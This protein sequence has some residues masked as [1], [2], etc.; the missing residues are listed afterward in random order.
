MRQDGDRRGEKSQR[1]ERGQLLQQSEPADEPRSETGENRELGGARP[2]SDPEGQAATSWKRDARR[3]GQ[4]D[5]R[6]LQQEDLAVQ[7]V[8]VEDG[9]PRHRLLQD[10]PAALVA[11]RGLPGDTEEE[12]VPETEQEV[13]WNRIVRWRDSLSRFFTQ[14]VISRKIRRKNLGTSG[15]IRIEYGIY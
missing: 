10:Q 13:R 8:Q 4:E 1:E 15:K 7:H 12:E 2:L 5:H 3:R 6:W 11:R 9:R 14:Y